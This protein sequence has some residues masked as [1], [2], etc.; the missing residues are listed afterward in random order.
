MQ[1]FVH[2]QYVDTS[3]LQSPSVK[4]AQC[5]ADSCWGLRG[6]ESHQALRVQ[7]IGGFFGVYY[8]YYCYYYYYYRLEP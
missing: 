1:D 4:P 2:Q 3:S 8:Y 6:L 5:I 7:L